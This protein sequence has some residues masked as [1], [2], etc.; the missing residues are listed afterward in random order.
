MTKTDQPKFEVLAAS[1]GR[2]L[3]TPLVS[4]EAFKLVREGNS[5]ILTG[6]LRGLPPG[7]FQ[8]LSV[9]I[10][11]D[12]PVV[13]LLTIAGLFP[14][15]LQAIEQTGPFKFRCTFSGP[16]ISLARAFLNDET[17]KYADAF[18]KVVAEEFP[19]DSLLNIQALLDQGPRDADS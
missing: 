8:G 14:G 17:K 16:V 15:H 3:K 2:F 13:E 18:S 4:T 6:T 5:G 11:I 9:T 1:R 19:E 12:A 10:S 7:L